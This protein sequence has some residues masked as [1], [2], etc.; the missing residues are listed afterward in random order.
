MRPRSHDR[1]RATSALPGQ[2]AGPHVGHEARPDDARL[3]AAGRADD[4]Q[5][6]V[7][8]Q[9]L[10][11]V[12]GQRLAPEEEL[13]V[14]LVEHL[15]PAERTHDGRLIEISPRRRSPGATPRMPST[16]RSNAAA[17]SRPVGSR[18]MSAGTGTE[19]AARD[20]E[21]RRRA[22]WP[23]MTRNSGLATRRLSAARISSFS[24]VPNPAG[25]TN[26]THV[27]LA[28]SAVSS[29]SC[30]GSPERGATRRGTAR[31]R[32]HGGGRPAP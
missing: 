14:L 6:P 5:E 17:S 9:L 21:G 1:P 8:A 18:P 20:R 19:A 4:G 10:D 11:Q 31:G 30:H 13:G 16:R 28:S 26:T 24:Q 12:L 32:H 23:G 15:Q 3:A 25:P 27:R 29:A 2:L 22:G 7:A